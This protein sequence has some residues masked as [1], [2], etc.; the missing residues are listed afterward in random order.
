MSTPPRI[1]I[2]PGEPA[3]IGPELVARLLAEPDVAQAAS[4]LLVGDRHVFE[5]GPA[6]GRRRLDLARSRY[7]RPGRMAA[8][9]R[10]C[11]PGDGD[12]RPG[13][14]PARRGVRGRRPIEPAHFGHRGGSGDGRYGRRRPF[15][16]VQQGVATSC[17]DGRRRR[18]SLHRPPYRL[19]RPS[20]RSEHARRADDDP[21]DQ[22]HRPQGRG[23]EHHDY[24]GGQG[25]PSGS[26]H[27]VGRRRVQ[28]ADRRCG[29]QSPCGGQR[30]FRRRGNR[31]PGAGH[32]KGKGVSN[33]RRRPLAVRHRFSQG[34]RR[35]CWTR[36]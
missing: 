31:R 18:A 28:A 23:G 11:A 16:P 9:G 20:Q 17:R 8:G 21:G 27:A 30:Q 24:R 4:I 1:A 25:H 19:H 6:A 34:P 2:I 36:S 10:L 13:R 22:P 26:R 3:G 7:R 12:D 29:D 15:R 5:S 33:R 14:N 32:R 35:P